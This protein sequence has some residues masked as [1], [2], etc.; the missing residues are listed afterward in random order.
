MTNYGKDCLRDY[1]NAITKAERV[2]QEAEHEVWMV[3]ETQDLYAI[4]TCLREAM[5]KVQEGMSQALYTA[6]EQE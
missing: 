4:S 2:L 5:N 3:E 6:Q 1:I